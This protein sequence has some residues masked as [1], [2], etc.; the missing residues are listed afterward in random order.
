MA[1][2]EKCEYT[3]KPED[4]YSSDSNS[5]TYFDKQLS[6]IEEKLCDMPD[7]WEYILNLRKFILKQQKKLKK[8]RRKLKV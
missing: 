6:A 5:S 1:N 3:A 7:I 4:C 8:L 2:T